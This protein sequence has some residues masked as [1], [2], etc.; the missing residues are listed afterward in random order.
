MASKTRESPDAADRDLAQRSQGLF[1]TAQGLVSTLKDRKSLLTEFKKTLI[2][3][4][5]KEKLFDTVDL[6]FVDEEIEKNVSWIDALE[7]A[8]EEANA[9]RAEVGAKAASIESRRREVLDQ[10]EESTHVL[11]MHP[12][13]MEKFVKKQQAMKQAIH[14]SHL[15]IV[16]KLTESTKFVIEEMRERRIVR[17]RK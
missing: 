14:A 8:L 5:T 4:G 1:E 15:T 13:M 11:D 2:E 9:S 17:D 10:I 7:K 12:V 6:G 3:Y 16:N